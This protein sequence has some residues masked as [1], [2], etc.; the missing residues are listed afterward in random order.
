[1]SSPATPEAALAEEVSRAT[2]PSEED[3]SGTAVDEEGYD[4]NDP[5]D[6]G[7]LIENLWQ[8]VRRA[9]LGVND[10]DTKLMINDREKFDAWVDDLR[11]AYDA[12]VRPPYAD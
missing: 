9:G 6:T 5:H 3:D 8:E 1:M 11:A 12:G 10:R 2:E 7:S 4:P